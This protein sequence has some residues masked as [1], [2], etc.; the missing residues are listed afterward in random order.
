MFKENS[1]KPLIEVRH[2]DDIGR[3]IIPKKI[4]DL[5][6]IKEGEPLEVYYSVEDGRVLFQ[7]IKENKE[8]QDENC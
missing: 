5:L 6:Q 4:R 2:T 7:K 8:E 3:I 1:M